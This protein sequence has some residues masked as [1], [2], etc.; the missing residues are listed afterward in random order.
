MKVFNFLVSLISRGVGVASKIESFKF[1]SGRGCTKC[2]NLK[3]EAKK[4]TKND[5]HLEIQVAGK[6][7]NDK[8]IL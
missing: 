8:K 3:M 1:F 6:R 5:S 7:K 4:L 2:P